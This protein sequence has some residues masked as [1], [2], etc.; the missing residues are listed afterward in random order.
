MNS[1]NMFY[2]KTVTLVGG[3]T[4]ILFIHKR[5]NTWHLMGTP[6]HNYKK[7]HSLVEMTDEDLVALILTVGPLKEIKREYS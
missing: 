6:L 2:I 4:A 3:G 1:T 7:F 5:Y